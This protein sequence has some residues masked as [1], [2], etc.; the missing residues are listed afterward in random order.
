M[1]MISMPTK[2]CW[3]NAMHESQRIPLAPVTVKSGVF[4][5]SAYCFTL[6]YCV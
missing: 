4:V 6:E 2:P 1:A 5:S 3:V